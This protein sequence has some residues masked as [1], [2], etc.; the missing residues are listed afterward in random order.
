MSKDRNDTIFALA[1]APGRAGVAVIRVSGPNAD[2]ALRN[3]THR[4]LP[5]AR[6]AAIRSLY[7]NSNKDRIDAAL[8]VRFTAPHSYTGEDVIEFQIHG[9]PAVTAALL[10][11][12]AAQPGLRAAEPGEFTRRAVL[13][14]RLD[15]TQAEAIADLVTAE[16][17]AQRR[18]AFRQFEGKL[19]ELYEE[20]RARLIRAAA[21]IEASI[22]FADEDIPAS[23]AAESRSAL[24]WVA[25]EIRAHL[26]DGRRGEILRDGLQ[27]AIIGPPNAGKSSLLNALARRDVAIVSP[28]PGTTRDVIEV[29]L[30]LGGYPV[31][32][33]DTAG[34]R[35]SVDAI[36]E[37]GVR[38]ARARA[39]SAD[40]CLLVLDATQP[41]LE[42]YPPLEGGSNREAVRGGERCST[43]PSPKSPSRS[44]SNE[45]STLPQGE[46]REDAATIVV[47]NKADLVTDRTRPGLWVS[48]KTGEGLPALIAALASHAAS[49]LAQNEAPVITRARYR[50]ALGEAVKALDLAVATAEPE[51]AAE[52]VRIALRAIGRITGRVDLDELL[53]VVFRDFCIG[54]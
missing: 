44:R 12:L 23:A 20:W 43:I 51:L 31:I 28:T 15:L 26:D 48:A 17:E 37:E 18:Q 35:D 4:P 16:T 36:E 39:Q 40:L 29:R 41:N 22:D 47:W 7:G 9:G 21:W 54:K 10:A 1:S 50:E 30:D 24:Q 46:G 14:G 11:A 13:N 33:A 25:D 3:L 2:A 42:T 53:D 32:L 27:V 5:A 34:L 19:G 45:I 8:I 6:M 38:R 49:G 52:H